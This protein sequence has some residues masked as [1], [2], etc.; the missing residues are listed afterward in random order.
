MRTIIELNSL[1][2]SIRRDIVKMIAAA[3][4]GHPGGSLSLVE[5]MVAL[6][7][8]DIMNHDAKDPKGKNRDRFVL[9]KGHAAPVLYAVLAEAGYISKDLLPTLRKLGSPLQGH[10][11]LRK[12]DIL[13][14][15]SGSLGQGI[16][17]GI[18]MALAARLDHLPGKIYIAVGDGEINEGQIWEAALFA[19]HHH[20]NNLIV[21]VD[22]NGFQLDEANRKILDL[23]PLADKWAAFN[24]NVMVIDGHDMAS[25][26]GALQKAGQS[27]EKPTVIIAK[28][29]KGKGVSFMENNNK[30]HGMAPTE[31]ELSQALA[32]LE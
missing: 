16:S 28:T 29:V 13:E 19:G 6:Y 4:S 1:A 17:V 23:N 22:H 32:E 5:I 20:L 10:P 9:S 25:V 2:K 18:G 8:G 7:F 27:A 30:F 24:W 31:T 26:H 3:G 11:D 14:I 21:I 12:L 15:S